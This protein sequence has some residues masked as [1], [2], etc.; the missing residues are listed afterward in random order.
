MVTMK[1]CAVDDAEAVEVCAL[2]KLGDC[3]KLG[4]QSG[5]RSSVS[6]PLLECG[7]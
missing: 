6:L 5:S 4:C 2:C 3:C 7:S 1:I